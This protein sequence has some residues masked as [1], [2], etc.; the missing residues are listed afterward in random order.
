MSLEHRI[1]RHVGR[2]ARDRVRSA[3]RHARAGRPWP[4]RNPLTGRVK[5]AHPIRQIARLPVHR[6]VR[7]GRVIGAELLRATAL[8]LLVAWAVLFLLP[9]I[10]QGAAVPF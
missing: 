7:T 6:P 3:L 9:I 5:R 8:A 4:P 2:P 10:L 1:T